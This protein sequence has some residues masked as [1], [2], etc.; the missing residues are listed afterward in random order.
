MYMCT[1]AYIC[2][3]VCMD[4]FCMYVHICMDVYCMYVHMFACELRL[5]VYVYIHLCVLDYMHMN[6]YLYVCM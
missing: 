4:V 3:C 6:A 2:I 5:Y 1:D